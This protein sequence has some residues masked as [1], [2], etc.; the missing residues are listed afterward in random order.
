MDSPNST[1]DLDLTPRRLER[2]R[3]L[4]PFWMKG[5]IWVFMVIGTVS[6]LMLFL[7]KFDDLDPFLT[8]GFTDTIFGLYGFDFLEPMTPL[9]VALIG[10][11]VLKGIASYGLWMEKGWGVNLGFADG[12]AGI[13]FC[14]MAMFGYANGFRFELFLLLLYL[15]KLNDIRNEWE[16]RIGGEKNFTD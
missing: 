6:P 14:L 2:R 10:T 3:T 15:W 7:N 11:W 5:F 16:E 12:I 1:L 8:L 9:G 13:I 4:L